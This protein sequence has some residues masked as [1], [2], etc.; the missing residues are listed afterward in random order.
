LTNNTLTNNESGAEGGGAYVRTYSDGSAMFNNIIWEN[1]A[2]A[3]GNDLFV[4]VDSAAQVMLF[5]NNLGRNANFETANSPDLIITD[6]TNY[7]QGKNIK[8]D[9]LL[10]D[11]IHLQYGSPGI[12]AGDNAVLKTFYFQIST[13]VEGDP[14]VIDG[15]GDG[16]AV[17]D[18]GA[19][20]DARGDINKDGCVDRTDADIILHNVRA[21]SDDTEDDIN[22]DGAINRADVRTVVKLYNNPGGESCKT[23]AV[24]LD[25]AKRAGGAGYDIGN[26]IAIDAIGNSM[27]TGSFSSRATFGA[28]EPNEI[29]LTSAGSNDI[30]ITMYAPDGSL[31][32]AKQA[33]GSGQFGG[34]GKTDQ[35]QGIALDTIGNSLVTGSFNGVATFG[36]E[37][38]NETV[39]TSA[40]HNDIFVAKYASDG[41]L[42]WVAQAGGVGGD[43]DKGIAVDAMGNSLITG[44]YRDSATFGAGEPNETVLRNSGTFV[45]KYAPGGSLVWAVR[46]DGRSSGIAVDAA[47]NSV[48]TGSFSGTTIFGAGEQNETVLTSAGSSDIFI[49][50]YGLNGYLLWAKQANGTNSNNSYGIAVDTSGNN[51]ITGSFSGST[52]FGAGEPNETILTSTGSTDIFTAMYAPNGSLVWAVQAGGISWGDAGKGITVDVEGNSMITGSFTG[53]ATF[54]AGEPNET[55]LASTGNIDIFI[56]KYAPHGSLVWAIQA[57]AILGDSGNG[58]AVDS[59]GKIIVTGYFEGKSTFGKGEPNETHLRSSG[60]NDIFIAKYKP[61]P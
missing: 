6:T 23:S 2:S 40:G 45:A 56:A 7:S 5:N 26:G 39:I 33:G 42:I 58:I 31:V 44:S 21:S 25:F 47:N 14:R 9:P 52:T 17:V 32:W 3:D 53:R 60:N 38:P 61:I 24:A 22:E 37:E 19:D 4:F 46:S 34:Q 16:N 27:V 48:I 20:E 59:M 1:Q 8:S 29:M 41:S 12:D 15:N 36:V 18:I 57:G 13:D 54:G 28:G 49:A 51:V 11:D 10:T 35:G 30:F 43:Q 50:K 55:V